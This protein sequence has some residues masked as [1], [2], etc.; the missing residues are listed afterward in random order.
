MAPGDTPNPEDLTASVEVATD[1]SEAESAEAAEMVEALAEAAAVE[2][3]TGDAPEGL[4]STGVSDAGDPGPP[5]EAAPEEAAAEEGNEDPEEEAEEEAPEPQA[6]FNPTM[7]DE[8]QA[9]M[10]AGIA[11]GEETRRSTI[12]RNRERRAQ[13]QASIHATNRPGP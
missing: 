8:V 6:Q 5:P 9:R 11:Q 3:E 4:D 13:Q 1:V 7:T 10:N 2:A 12:R